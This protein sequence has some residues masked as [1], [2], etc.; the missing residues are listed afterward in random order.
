MGKLFNKFGCSTSEDHQFVRGIPVYAVSQVLDK[1][2]NGAKGLPLLINGV[3]RP[4]PLVRIL[5]VELYPT[6][7]SKA[8]SF[9]L[10]R[11]LGPSVKKDPIRRQVLRVKGCLAGSKA[12]NL[13]EQGDMIS[14][15]G[16]RASYLLY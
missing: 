14:G 15:G 12:E 4:M 2:I 13:L 10:E 5:E 3:S 9:A 7:L 6:L 1:I 11:S 8:R 16:Q